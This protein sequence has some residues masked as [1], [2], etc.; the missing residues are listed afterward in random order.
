MINLMMN[1]R[2]I[3]CLLLLCLALS[4]LAQGVAEESEPAPVVIGISTAPAG[5]LGLGL[6]SDNAADSDLRLLLHGYETVSW[7][8]SLGAAFNQTAL[9]AVREEP[10]N[11]G[12]VVVVFE[13]APGLAYNDGTAITA[14]DYV[15]SALLQASPALAALGAR[16]GRLDY[17]Q[18]YIAYHTGAAPMLSGVRLLSET[19]FSLRVRAD[20]LPNFYGFAMLELLP[21]PISVIAPGCRV[22]DA[23]Q[24]AY[25]QDAPGEA[26]GQRAEARYT[27]GRFSKEM[28]EAT[29]LDP[30]TGYEAN[31]RVTC[32][33]YYLEAFDADARIAHLR[34]NP[35]YIGNFEGVKP[36]VERLEVRFTRAEEMPA[37]LRSGA[38]DIVTRVADPAAVREGQALAGEGGS[39]RAVPYARTGL[40]MLAFA[41]ERGP[42]ASQAVR[43]AV[44]LCLDKAAIAQEIG[45]PYA[46]RVYGY[47]GKDQ[48]MA[49][50]LADAGDGS[51]PIDIAAALAT[52]DIPQDL[53]AAKAALEADRWTLN[54]EGAPFQEGVDPMR[55]REENGQLVPLQLWMA[56]PEESAAA[57]QISDALAESLGQAGIGLRSVQ[58]SFSGVLDQYYR[59][60]DR[61]FDLFF[62]STGF[63]YLFDPFYEVNPGEAMQGLANKTGIQDA[64][65]AELAR[66]LR[67]TPTLDRDMYAIKWLAFQQRFMAVLP[68]LPL[69][70]N[71]YFDFYT[72][73]L[74]E[75]AVDQYSGWA[76]SVP[77]MRLRDDK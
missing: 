42:L 56:L 77:Y 60:Q 9:S 44:A 59:K 4:P 74:R 22:A 67:A 57:R 63:S 16:P 25:I 35:R 49:N 64:A 21:Y 46:E 61:V 32:G 6:W 24:G 26:A 18:G 69:Y 43:R 66:D 29:L 45:G 19:S 38:L 8:R 7:T 65:L 17:L 50:F 72:D 27:P 71:T 48:W 68:V 20:A 5:N 76:L 13:L 33:A 55:Y 39:I 62:L 51:M 53:A 10:Q 58:T 54:A 34:I 70:S 2:T 11:D 12:D 14:R 3:S 47:Y 40:T 75:Y 28:L 23:G 15:F 1:K 31:P 30:A 36:S 41:C 52:L 37:L 73:R